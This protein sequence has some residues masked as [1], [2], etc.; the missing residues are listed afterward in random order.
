MSIDENYNRSGFLSDLLAKAK[1]GE[2]LDLVN[3]R[4]E[5]RKKIQSE[6]KTFGKFIELMESFQD[7]LPK[8]KQRYNVAIK[9][10]ATT[11]GLGRQS[12]LESTDNQIEELKALEN[13]V[14][15]ALTGV[16]DE[17][18]A[19][20][21]RSKEIKKEIAEL[22]KKMTKFE[23]EEQE[24]LAGMAAR[25]SEMKV[26]EDGVRKAFTDVGTEITDIRKKIEE[27]TGE[28]VSSGQITPPDSI[29]SPKVESDKEGIEE[30]IKTGEIPERG[31]TEWTRRC[32]LCGGR[33]NFHVKEGTW[34]CYTC[35]HEAAQTD[36]A[37]DGGEPE[38]ASE[39]DKESELVSAADSAPAR[40]PAPYKGSVTANEHKPTHVASKPDAVPPASSPAVKRPST[41]KKTCPVCRKQMN[42][43]EE[44]KTW[45]CPF[46]DYQRREF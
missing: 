45:C 16:R 23:K 28:K 34:M 30:E 35:G 26:V 20:E 12:V 19:M 40:E 15:S 39:P 27:F 21:S 33:M 41:R 8:E 10:L 1:E 44:E 31:D 22:R 3:L 6:D 18:E 11:T 43:N 7:I 14:L 46:C 32:P 42:M 24:L 38:S 37:E 9:A 2:G 13:V 36:D 4:Y 29:E 5:I 17:L 25:E